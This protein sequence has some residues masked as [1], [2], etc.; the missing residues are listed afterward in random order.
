MMT[1][2]KSRQIKFL[3]PDKNLTLIPN[4]IIQFLNELYNKESIFEIIKYYILCL[5]EQNIHDLDWYLTN[6]S[7]IKIAILSESNRELKKTIKSLSLTK[8]FFKIINNNDFII[9]NEFN[10]ICSKFSQLEEYQ[11]LFSFIDKQLKKE[12]KRKNKN[13]QK[14]NFWKKKYNTVVTK[15]DSNINFSV[16]NDDLLEQEQTSNNLY[17][18]IKNYKSL[19]NSSLNDENVTHEWKDDTSV[20]FK[21]ADGTWGKWVNLKPNNSDNNTIKRG[22]GGGIGKRKVQAMIDDTIANNVLSNIPL[23]IPSSNGLMSADD[24]TQLTLFPLTSS[25]T[26]KDGITYVEYI[27]FVS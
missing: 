3:H 1:N 24:K 14:T 16:E 5:Q 4:D 7:E 2:T 21:N 8:L 22:G 9:I 17:E 23:A 26:N 20:R 19:K 25:Q 10:S 6:K 11:Q 13:Q 18:K 27:N 12:Q 15:K